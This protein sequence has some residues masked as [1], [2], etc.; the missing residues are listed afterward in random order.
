ML[1]NLEIVAGKMAPQ[2]KML[3]AKP[4]DPSSVPKT[5]AELTKNR[6]R[7]FSASLVYLVSS[8]TTRAPP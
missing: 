5:H 8:R 4:E 2:V 1:R 6:L 3:G 7:E